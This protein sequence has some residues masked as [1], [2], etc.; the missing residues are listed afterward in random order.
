MAHAVQQDGQAESATSASLPPLK[1]QP[2]KPRVSES[3]RTG[4]SSARLQEIL[5]KAEQIRV[6]EADFRCCGGDLK[7]LRKHS[8]KKAEQVQVQEDSPRDGDSDESYGS[9]YAKQCSGMADS[10]DP[11]RGQPNPEELRSH[12]DRDLLL[13]QP[14]FPP[15]SPPSSQDS[16]DGASPTSPSLRWCKSLHLIKRDSDSRGV[17][18]VRTGKTAV[19]RTTSLPEVPLPSMQPPTAMFKNLSPHQKSFRVQQRIQLTEVSDD[20][21]PEDAAG[22]P[23]V[24]ETAQPAQSG[25]ASV[26]RHVWLAVDKASGEV[27][28]Y[29]RAASERIEEAS[30][31]GRKSVPLAGLGQGVDGA[32]VYFG[33]GGSD[34]ILERNFSGAEREACRKEV[35][36]NA[37]EVRVNI[38]QK[39]C[40]WAFADPAACQNTEE[41]L[42]SVTKGDMARPASPEVTARHC[43]RPT[44]FLNMGAFER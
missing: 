2:A 7:L 33:H 26:T 17:S 44:F 5:G 29:P 31:H 3:T 22:S 30:R 13:S 28:L 42:V 21:S 10:R 39:G 25:S 9:T 18:R 14:Y 27:F 19:A 11:W 1:L 32:I 12:G 8:M 34:E 6:T 24:Q 4:I 43:R 20:A 38:S 23:L 16:Q 41:R 36:G 35:W 37:E 40:L 15:P